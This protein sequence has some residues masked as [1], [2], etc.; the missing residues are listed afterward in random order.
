MPWA[1]FA[2]SLSHASHPASSASACLPRDESASQHLFFQLFDR[3]HLLAVFLL[4]ET[5]LSGWKLQL[6][7]LDGP[8]C[9]RE[10]GAEWV[11]LMETCLSGWKLQLRGLDGAGCERE[12]GAQWV[13]RARPASL[14]PR[15]PHS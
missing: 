7:G 6:R 3:V 10:A 8:G 14:P 4:M 12:A 13:L 1:Y 11:L 2:H 9:E 15:R 5:S